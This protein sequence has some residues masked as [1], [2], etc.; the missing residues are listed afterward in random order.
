MTTRWIALLAIA[1]SLG[2]FTWASAQEALSVDE[3][4]KK[5]NHTSYYQG[6]DGSARVKMTI[7]DKQGRSREKEF[8]I[9]R[10]NNDDVEPESFTGETRL[11]EG[12]LE[13]DSLDALEITILIEEEYGIIVEVAERNEAIFGTLASLAQF[14]R[15]HHRRDIDRI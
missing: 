15:E 7:V 9:L 12:G 4:V 2:A 3:I 5:T 11:F 10:R 6:K 14:V 8:T 1:A 13:L